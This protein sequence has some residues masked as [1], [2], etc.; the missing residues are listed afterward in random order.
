[1][2]FIE[3][4]SNTEAGNKELIL[5]FGSQLDY[6]LKSLQ[7]TVIGSVCDQYQLLKSMEEQM[8]SFLAKKC[9]VRRRKYWIHKFFF[10]C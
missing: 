2:H 3:R 1:M 6:S 10:F 9:E 5:K 4:Q 7:N 8:S